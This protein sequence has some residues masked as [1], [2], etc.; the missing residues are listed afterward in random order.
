MT[1][2]ESFILTSDYA[3]LKNDAV[4]SLTVVLPSG[5]VIPAGGINQWSDTITIGTVGSSIRVR[6]VSTENNVIYSTNT[7][8]YVHTTGASGPAT[9]Y[10]IYATVHRINPTQ[11]RLT[12]FI[13]NPYGSDLTVS[14]MGYTISAR[15]AT[16]LSP[17][18]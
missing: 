2:P 14:G 8:G 16:F 1:K 18:V 12:V 3:T 10:L 7:V 13:P 11:V 15:I 4:G 6:L 5:T 9:D 17:F